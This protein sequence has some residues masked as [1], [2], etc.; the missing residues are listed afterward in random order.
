M[1]AQNESQ[2]K[3][4]KGT[5]M[6]SR[7][8]LIIDDSKVIIRSLRELL[9][10]QSYNIQ[11]AINSKE[12]LKKI[13]AFNP[14]LILLD[15]ML[16]VINGI[17]L[18]K[19]FKDNPSTRSVP[20]I[21]VTGKDSK[22]DIIKGLEAGADDYITKPFD[23][24]EL[25]S[26]V[27]AHLR[28]KE[29][30]EQLEEEKKDL[31]EIL[32]IMEL[33]TSTLKSNGILYTLVKKIADHAK[34]D[35]CSIVKIGNK[36]DIAYVIATHE[37]PTIKNLPIHLDKYPE[38]R[39]AL[40]TKEPVIIDDVE[41]DPIMKDVRNL[42]KK[43]GFGSIMVLPLFR[44]EKTVGVLFLR[45]ARKDNPF[46]EGEIRF[47][48]ILASAA[49]RALENIGLYEQMEALNREL[50]RESITDGL[51]QLY[52]QRYFYKKLEEEFDRAR[53]YMSYLS[54]IMIDADDFKKINDTFGHRQ[55]DH[56]LKEIATVFKK[57]V[58]KTDILARYGG[59]EF[60]ILLPH[61][62]EEG[63]Y[64]HAE[65][66]RK[67]VHDH[68]YT[69]MDIG[70]IKLSISLGVATYPEKDINTDAD[71]IKEADRALYSAKRNRGNKTASISAIEGR[72][73][74]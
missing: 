67:A 11:E 5:H 9:E 36:K 50:A 58:R 16:P 8:I 13:K 27:R 2:R 52:N 43:V 40:R 3:V 72:E 14:D 41:N 6:D 25:L 48:R 19:M 32:N 60:I 74:R 39:L 56:L 24:Q 45:A 7:K 20:I 54:C 15:V 1:V 28:S 29:L 26:R 17:K 23:G 33:M 30:Y 64:M 10:A 31:A 42:L 22:K 68:S 18:C 70:D 21:M 71:L 53:R 49:A 35:R 37:D 69:S 57:A 4:T 59:D 38:I 44:K 47:C 51:T 63:A 73:V 61:T 65:R 55:G 62:N 66:I 12:A 46:T 34:I